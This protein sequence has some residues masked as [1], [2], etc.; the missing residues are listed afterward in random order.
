MILPYTTSAAW[1]AASGK[2]APNT[3]PI[4]YSTTGKATPPSLGEQAGLNIG[5]VVSRFLD[6]GFDI[7]N[8]R[9]RQSQDYN[10]A[11]GVVTAP[12]VVDR[13]QN[14]GGGIPPVVL[15]AGGAFAVWMLT[16]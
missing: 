4:V 12:G 1:A 8:D 10:Q 14:Y 5:S 2:P 6:L 7:A 15:L 3:T 13:G 9:L 11:P 16:K